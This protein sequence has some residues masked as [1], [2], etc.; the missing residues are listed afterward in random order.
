MIQLIVN[1]KTYDYPENRDSP[2]WGEEAT[3][4][5]TAVTNVLSNVVGNGD[6]LQTAASIANNQVAAA[7]VSGL[8]FDPTVVRG[9][10]VEYSIYRVTTSAGATEAVEVGTMYLGFKSTANTWDISVVG[11]SGAGVTFS[12]T[13]GGQVQ[14]TS[15]N[16]TGSTYSGTMKFRARALTI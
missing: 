6:I 13:A 2:G 10:I 12:I 1:G 7:N 14:Y 9:A 16:F 15:T 4:W 8:I 3:A 5:A 11:G